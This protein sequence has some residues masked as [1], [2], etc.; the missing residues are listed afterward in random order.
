MVDERERER[1]HFL[2]RIVIKEKWF[3]FTSV[4]LYKLFNLWV[5]ASKE[6]HVITHFLGCCEGQRVNT[7]KDFRAVLGI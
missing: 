7:C 1:H 5:F 3:A 6:L 4:S 2:V